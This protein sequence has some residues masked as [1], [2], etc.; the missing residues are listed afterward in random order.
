VLETHP[1]I[2]ELPHQKMAVVH[3]IG[4]PEYVMHLALPPLCSSVYRLKC[5][6]KKLGNDFRLDHFRVRLLNSPELP[7]Q[8]WHCVWGLPIPE[9]TTSLPQRF[10]YTEVEIETWQYGMTAQ[11][12]YRGSGGHGDYT[13]REQATAFLRTYIALHGYEAAGYLE[14][15]YL[16]GPEP[17]LQRIRLRLPVKMLGIARLLGP[18]RQLTPA[19]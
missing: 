6:R 7:R 3:T 15:E 10:P 9:D 11:V 14:E 18:T 19:R 5:A 13:P 8:D 1:E 4:N 2:V 12:I 16:V 17:E